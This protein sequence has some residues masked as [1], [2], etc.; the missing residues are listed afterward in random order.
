M[1]HPT[2]AWKS[3]L[4][5]DSARNVTAGS[6][7]ALASAIARGADLR[8]YTDF[9]HNEHI[10]VTSKNPELVQEVSEFAVTYLLR[11]SWSAGIMTLRQP[12]NL[13]LGFGRPSMSF[14]LYNQDGEQAIA[15]PHL[16]GAPAAGELGPSP[17]VGHP[18]MAKYHTRTAWDEKT[19][20]PSHNFVYDFGAFRFCVSDT[21]REVFAN[22]ADGKPAGGS[23]DE[24][25]DAFLKA[26]EM[27]VA[28]RDLCTDL[29]GSSSAAP[30]EHEVFV[31]VGPGY[32]YTEQRLFMSGSHPLV[33]IRPNIP[34][35]YVSRGWDFGWL[36]LRTDGRAVYRKCDPYSLAFQDVESRYAIRWFVR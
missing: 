4:E 26:C 35:Q 6:T 3:V 18:G 33:R 23:L 28:V 12:V 5:L 10:D 16:D 15:R 27:K 34:M 31:R 30:I 32:Y 1:Q 21:W 22:D 9:R 8:I 13:P 29:A 25:I 24:L 20:A 11:M 36:M 2:T 7:A 14:F 19:N 17:A